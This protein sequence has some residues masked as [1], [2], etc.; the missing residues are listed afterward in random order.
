MRICRFIYIVMFLLSSTGPAQK[1]W[2]A[3]PNQAVISP[4][5]HPD[6]RV[7]FRLLSPDAKSVGVNVQ[8]A[9]GLV[10][11][12]K[13]SSGLWSVTL[14]PVEPNIYEYSFLV[15][16]LQIVD[17]SNS[18]FKV[19]LRTTKNLVLVPGDKPL[20]FE[21][22]NVPHGTIHIHKYRSKS[23]GITRGLYVYT[24]PGYETSKNV[25][26]PVLY[27]LHG[28]GDSEDAWTVVGRVNVIIDNLL[29][30]NKARPMVIV[31][32]YGHTPS[33]PPDMS[34]L[35]K[36]DDFEKDLISDVIP[37]IQ[38]QY[39]VSRNQKDRA[40]AGLS[41]GGGQSLTVGLG[42]LKLFGWIGAFS[43]AVPPEQK[44]DKL[45]AEPKSINKR[46]SLLWIGCGNEDF[47]FQLN[48]KFL[49]RLNAENI[50]H[51]SRITAGT[52]DWRLWRSYLNEFVPLLFNKAEKRS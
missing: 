20:F 25:R 13:E 12:S 41:M 1:L 34:S 48:Q 3:Q 30:E 38:K 16:G 40:I 4:E 14:G 7:T 31:M 24:P 26:Y 49:E 21:E 29:A 50:R 11:M 46:L 17:P 44:L 10:P 42:N 45:L 35:D 15:D 33:A 19:W 37:Y 9:Q 27:L 47:L 51:V 6:R 8:F 43:S 32:P 39:H 2:A 52:H 5:V 23:L 36:Y 18:W 28:L 22:Q